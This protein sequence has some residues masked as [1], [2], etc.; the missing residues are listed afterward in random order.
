ML[1][2][3][4]PHPQYEFAKIMCSSGMLVGDQ[5]E[6]SSP[7]DISFWPIHPT[8]ERLWAAKKL[9]NMF[10]DET[11]PDGTSSYDNCGGHDVTDLIPLQVGWIEERGYRGSGLGEGL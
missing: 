1:S 10:T 11:W 5:I 9:M 6:A 7:Y 2:V 3:S 8:A 4:F